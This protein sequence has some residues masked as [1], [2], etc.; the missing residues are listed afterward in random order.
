MVY[1]PESGRDVPAIAFGHDWLTGIGGYVQLF[2]HLASWGIVVAAPD[3]ERGV[4]PSVLTMGFDLGTALD[5]A[6]GVRLGP[7]QI[8]VHPGKLGVVGHGFGASAAVFA[9]AGMAVKPAAVAAIFPS[10]STPPAESPAA[11]L[12]APGLILSAPGDATALNAD[13]PALARVWTSATARVIEK[14]EPAGLIEGRRLTRVL[15]L[16]GSD[17]RTQRAVRAML[18]G[19]LLATV[20][21][22]KHYRDFADPHIAVPGTHVLDIDTA[23]ATA[24]QKIAALL[25]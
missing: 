12:T 16:G 11:S 14:A 25:K 3:T 23:P 10:L 24:E 18:T 4:A 21:A 2:E 8:S 13:A 5:I 15:G 1:T 17:R 19:Y 9:A 20:G 22:D 7:G 6:A